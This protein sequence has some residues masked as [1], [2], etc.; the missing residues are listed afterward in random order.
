MAASPAPAV[1]AVA[2]NPAVVAAVAL[3]LTLTALF[4]A[5]PLVPLVPVPLPSAVAGVEPAVAAAEAPPN[6]GVKL[7]ATSKGWET[8]SNPRRGEGEAPNCRGVCRVPRWVGVRCR[9]S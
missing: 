2:V 9:G 7:V 5:L 4:L 3:L 6:V 1:A 8:K